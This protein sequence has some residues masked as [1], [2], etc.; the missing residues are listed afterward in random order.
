MP[1]RVTEMFKKAYPFE[2]EGAVSP[3]N[4]SAR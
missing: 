2:D 1:E 3:E 4:K